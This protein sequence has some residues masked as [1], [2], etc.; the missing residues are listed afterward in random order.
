LLVAGFDVFG[1]IAHQLQARLYM[2]F[3]RMEGELNVLAF[4]PLEARNTVRDNWYRDV[5]KDV[6]VH[7]LDSQRLFSKNTGIVYKTKQAW[8]EFAGLWKQH[9]QPVLN[10]RF[11]LNA[12]TLPTDLT[13]LKQLA[14][15]KG[16]SVSYLPELSYLTV[17]D[18]QNQP[19]HFTL[20]R[21]SAHSNVSELFKEEKRRLPDE[22]TLTVTPGFIGSYPNAFYQLEAR[23]LPE[24]IRDVERMNS[25][26]DYT[27]LSARF[28]IRRTN[29]QFWKHADNLHEAYRKS[30]PIEAALFDFNRFENR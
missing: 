26:A 10:K 18:G 11:E 24:F 19:H 25:E 1:T 30:D 12:A 23:Q 13:S 3:L 15:L 6:N 5:P 28:A 20:L 16:K 21:N 8:P 29:P 22:D 2:D 9:L 27:Q 14:K 17:A 4:L 7:L